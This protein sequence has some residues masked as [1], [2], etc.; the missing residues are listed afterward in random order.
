MCGCGG[1][2][3]LP[4]STRIKLSVQ[5]CSGLRK[6]EEGQ[7]DT[8]SIEDAQARL[9]DAEKKWRTSCAQADEINTASLAKVKR[10]FKDMENAK[11]RL[12]AI[13]D[14]NNETTLIPN[15]CIVVSL[16]ERNRETDRLFH[17]KTMKST[18]TPVW[19]DQFECSPL[20]IHSN[21][22]RSVAHFEGDDVCRPGKLFFTVYHDDAIPSRDDGS[23]DFDFETSWR[24]DFPQTRTPLAKAWWDFDDIRCH[25]NSG[26]EISKDLDLYH[27]TSG[28][29]LRNAQLT[30]RAIVEADNICS[31][32]FKCRSRCK[33]NQKKRCK[34]KSICCF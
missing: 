11:R 9:K 27:P 26:T 13:P 22:R 23:E 18:R 20:G 29:K 34:K 19:N 31:R 4:L 33:C 15:P 14:N 25:I 7:I 21:C 5:N 8:L 3:S 6:L 28:V 17:S 32:L 24:R 12:N 10:D 2:T 30:I 1:C 16:D